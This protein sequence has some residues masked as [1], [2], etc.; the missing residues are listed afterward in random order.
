MFNFRAFQSADGRPDFMVT[1]GLAPPY[2]AEDV[3]A[4]YLSKAKELHP[5]H[6][7]TADEFHALQDAFEKAERY[8]EF[9]SDRQPD[10]RL[11]DG[12]KSH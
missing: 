5:D 10:A 1:L 12:W 8:L 3:K 7:G 11:S 4:A 2:A 6:G 9:R